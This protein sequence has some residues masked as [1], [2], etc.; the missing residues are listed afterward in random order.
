MKARGNYSNKV[1]TLSFEIAGDDPSVAQELLNQVENKIKSRLVHV[2]DEVFS[3]KSHSQLIVMNELT[4]DLGVVGV[5]EIEEVLEEKL[6][7]ALVVSLDDYQAK[8]K[9]SIARVSSHGVDTDT[10]KASETREVY[11]VRTANW[12][13]VYLQTGVMPW[14]VEDEVVLELKSYFKNWV[15]RENVKFADVVRRYGATAQ[16]RQRLTA[17]L[18]VQYVREALRVGT[19][20]FW[21]KVPSKDQAV[22]FEWLFPEAIVAS[23][24]LT[25]FAQRTF[26]IFRLGSTESQSEREALIRRLAQVYLVNRPVS[27]DIIRQQAA[28]LL[29]GGALQSHVSISLLLQGLKIEESRILDQPDTLST[30][31]FRDFVQLVE[32]MWK[33]SSDNLM[34][35]VTE[36]V[37]TEV[38]KKTATA[39][40]VSHSPSREV[41]IYWMWGILP[42]YVLTNEESIEEW[43][44]RILGDVVQFAESVK[45]VV[46]FM[47][48]REIELVMIRIV[49]S[50]V[51]MIEVE[52]IMAPVRYDDALIS[53]W[54]EVSFTTALY[55]DHE[56]MKYVLQGVLSRDQVPYRPQMSV[57]DYL[58]EMGRSHRS[59]LVSLIDLLTES[60]V[61]RLYRMIRRLI[62]IT[63]EGIQLNVDELFDLSDRHSYL[64][65]LP[66]FA[67]GVV[68][69]ERHGTQLKGQSKDAQ[70]RLVGQKDEKKQHQEAK[71]ETQAKEEELSQQTRE[72]TQ[73]RE[74]GEEAQ[75]E[76]VNAQEDVDGKKN[77]VSDEG[78]QELRDEVDRSIERDNK[79][80]NEED[81]SKRTDE[82]TQESR[83][84]K[85]TVKTGEVPQE[86]GGDEFTKE[87]DE[88]KG[89][90]L[91]EKTSE[92]ASE[93]RVEEGSD[94]AET[95]PKGSDPQ[96]QDEEG[97]RLTE[98]DVRSSIEE[99]EDVEKQLDR[100]RSSAEEEEA[101]I[102]ESKETAGEQDYDDSLRLGS[103]EM[104]VEDFDLFQEEEVVDREIE[105][106]ARGALEAS[107]FLT[108]AGIVLLGP[109]LTRLF[110]RLGLLDE[111]K[112]LVEPRHKQKAVE[113]MHYL[114]FGVDEVV[115]QHTILFKILADM[116]ISLP[117]PEKISLSEEEREICDGLLEAVISNWSMLKGSTIGNLRGSFLIREAKLLLD[118]SSYVLHV[119]EKPYDMLL[120]KLP[121]SYRIIKFKWMELPVQ[122]EW[123]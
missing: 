97:D 14:W 51:P 46:A 17:L 5:D 61:V 32:E 89:E 41:L 99:D 24:T 47:G 87:R 94:E 123:R 37:E 44:Q 116:P 112:N 95:K 7:Q 117:T 73:P 78:D 62:E 71:E 35:E 101:K 22:F 83:G 53:N 26:K 119:Q 90:E 64:Q 38:V 8:E 9:V 31:E 72:G 13:V 39:P 58:L 91:G 106:K 84:Q 81:I 93:Q 85:E 45:P 66:D 59:V 103:E 52:Q 11:D 30:E 12:Q 23:R 16:V 67:T 2:I 25:R 100:A 20:E 49:R 109:Y 118:K 40:P 111:Q 80:Q 18:G 33:G 54:R 36:A 28:L 57:R 69:R 55:Q 29:T 115:E 68:T 75:D 92:E 34:I 114:V 102:V 104:D 122:V 88:E 50:N 107:I 60:Q 10:T 15:Q 77:I 19:P 4:I 42:E 27:S 86:E 70:E 105:K 56:I 6:R 113:L 76:S 79:V 63:E 121:W 43:V 96:G 3:Q 21:E 1:R 98:E 110:G 120:D 48:L 82:E 108:S 74:E 65:D